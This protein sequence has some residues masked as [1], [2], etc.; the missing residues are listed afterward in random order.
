VSGDGAAEAAYRAW[1]PPVLQEQ[2]EV[3]VFATANDVRQLAPEQT[4]QGR[5]SHLVFVDLPTPPDRADIL[6][7]HLAKRGRDPGRFDL[8]ALAGATDGYAGAELEAGVTG[9]LLRAFLDGARELTTDDVL[10]ALR[11]VRPTSLV[12]REEI[13]EQ[14]RWARAHV[15]IDAVQGRPVGDGGDGRHLEL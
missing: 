15:A 12:K 6:R 10:Q 4:R 14:R 3:F 2:Q 13:E 7:V 1:H 5:F 11:A 8:E 9:G